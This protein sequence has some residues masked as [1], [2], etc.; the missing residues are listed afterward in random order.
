MAKA[1]GTTLLKADQ[2]ASGGVIEGPIVK[3][4]ETE[5]DKLKKPQGAGK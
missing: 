3:A 2:W 1:A 4:I 5:L